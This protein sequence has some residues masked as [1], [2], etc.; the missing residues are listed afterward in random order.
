MIRHAS[1]D[2]CQWCGFEHPRLAP[3]DPD[4]LELEPCEYGH[5]GCSYEFEG[6]CRNEYANPDWMADSLD[7][8]QEWRAYDD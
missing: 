6:P 1:R 2:M 5:Y 3:C 7:D 4:T 8:E